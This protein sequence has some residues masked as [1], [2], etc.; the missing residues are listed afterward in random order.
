V[1]FRSA[2]ILALV[3]ILLVT[4]ALV[5]VMSYRNSVFALRELSAQILEQTSQRVDQHVEST[6][7]VAVAQSKTYED[8]LTKS[9]I[10]VNDSKRMTEHFLGSIRANPQ[11]SYLSFATES[12]GEYWH[13]YNNSKGQLEVQFV[14]R[15]DDRM[16]L[17]DLKVLPDGKLERIRYED[18]TKRTDPR[19]RPYYGWA[20]QAKRQTWTETYLFMG[21]GGQFNIPGVTRATPIYHD[22]QFKGVL[23]A[24][25][26]LE[27]LS[28][29]LQTLRV[30]KTGFAFI[31]ELRRPSKDKPK[32][33]RRVIAHP[34]PS[35]LVRLKDVNDKSKGTDSVPGSELA[36]A[37]VRAFLAKLPDNLRNT[38]NEVLTPV[39]VDVGGD[40]YIGGYRKSG[41]RD[42]EWLICIMMPEADVMG[43]VY[44]NTRTTIIIVIFGIIVAIIVSLFLS[45]AIAK[46]LRELA[47]ESQS[48]GEFKLE[49]REP[50]HSYLLEIRQLAVALEE[51]KAS[52]RSF[53]KFVPADVV[54]SIIVSGK[55]ARLG[56]E[57]R[58]ICLFFCDIAGFT[59][60]AETMTPDEL[61]ELLGAF[62]G[63][64]SEEIMTSGGTVDK[65]IGDAIMAF[66]GAPKEVEEPAMAACRTAIACHQKLQ[67]LNPEW[68]KRGWPTIEMRIGIH[69]GDAIVGNF[70]S[71]DR[72][73]YT[74]IGDAVNL[75][76]RIEGLNKYYGTRIAISASTYEA[77]RERMV[78]RPLDRVSVTGREEGVLVYELIGSRDEVSEHDIKLAERHREALDAY[79]DGDWKRA[80]AI[81]EELA[82][83]RSNDVAARILLERVRILAADPPEKWDGVFRM[84]SK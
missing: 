34:D 68:N 75:S 9:A 38:P 45:A 55:E 10:D 58:D 21:S 36:D 32:G 29:F 25:F 54:R 40:T 33:E 22:G 37:R 48:I 64:M 78:A 73:D 27:A 42:L 3:S 53:K 47:E 11:L 35:L 7:R 57:R 1:K 16:T 76:S 30:G 80:E 74:A 46:T 63:A 49:G 12:Q 51:M 61:V 44:A 65:Y 26:D 15:K 39:S 79:F 67:A 20:K 50:K 28:K 69:L 83:R 59:S 60:I 23:T 62:L 31:V 82:E 43:S 81:F 84:T 17:E 24:D 14:V 4:V 66:W 52:L 8:L 19:K 72:L 5:G 70:G 6:L 41:V 18:S 77:V 13:V 71:E 2:Q 56:G